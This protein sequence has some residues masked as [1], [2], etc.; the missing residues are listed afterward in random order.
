MVVCWFILT[1]NPE[2]M[3]IER[4]E[5]TTSSEEFYFDQK[6]L[7]LTPKKKTNVNIFIFLQTIFFFFQFLT[8]FKLLLLALNNIK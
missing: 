7:S 2:D 1:V 4:E 5:P 8:T 6:R 3:E